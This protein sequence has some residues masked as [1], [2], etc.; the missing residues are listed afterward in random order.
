MSEPAAIEPR[1]FLRALF[2]EALAAADP[3]RVVPPH[4]P[5]PPAGRT[6]VVG[7]GKA[8][9][10]MAKALEQSWP[11]PL[12]GLVVTRTGHAVP[13]TRIEIV[14]ASHPV[15]DE[16]GRQAAG[17]ILELARGCGEDDLVIAL[18]SGGGSALLALP[19]EGITLEEKQDIN[20]ALLASGAR[21][22]E[23]NCLRKHLSAIKGGR[24]AAVAHPARVVALLISDVPGDDPSVIAS[25]PTVGDPSTR[26]DA[27][28]IID[29]YAIDASAGVLDLLRRAACETPKPGDPRLARAETRLIARPQDS[30]EAAARLAAEHDVTP[31]I[32]GD[33]IEGEAREVAIVMAGIA[34]Q[35]VRHGQP[36]AP[37]CV[38]LSGGETT[39]TLRAKGRGGRNSEFLLSLAI[40]LDG[41]AGVHA[42]ACDTD[43]IDGSED[44]AGAIIGPDSLTRAARLGLSAKAKLGGNDAYG[45]FADLGD[46][47]VS[48]PTLTN[49]NDFRA[50]LIEKRL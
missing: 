7:A 12:E 40:V 5:E 49:V 4:L 29:K 33:A 45:F 41:L 11:G 28:E 36:A 46:L 50:I 16:A 37:P 43:G 10:A 44:N 24:L 22:D 1:A 23:M 25:G 32:L 14:E 27:L 39:V 20:R 38:L 13:C 31:L 26:E 18:V 35:A 19:A 15:P 9:A 3:A 48:G 47:V 42:I 17:R 21:I 30:L 34:R 6:V 8:S 2:D